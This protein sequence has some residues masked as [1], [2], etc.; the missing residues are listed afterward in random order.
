MHQCSSEREMRVRGRDVRRVAVLDCEGEGVTR[1]PLRRRDITGVELDERQVRQS[2]RGRGETTGTGERACFCKR[3]SR[4]LVATQEEERLPQR[5]ES[6]V[7][8]GASV[9]FLLEHEA[10]CTFGFG[11][12]PSQEY[13][14]DHRDRGAKRRDSVRKRARVRSGGG[15]LKPVLDLVAS[16]PA[17]PC[18][19]RARD[20]ELRSASAAGHESASSQ[21]V[22]VPPR[23]MDSRETDARVT[24]VLARSTFLL[25]IACV[26]ACS[27]SPVLLMPV[28][29]SCVEPGNGGGVSRF[30]LSPQH[31]REELVV[32][33]LGA[34]LVEPG[35]EEVQP[36]DL[37]ERRCGP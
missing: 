2:H 37:L 10:G 24:S 8:P 5:H 18:G 36:G 27:M 30:E 19:E 4:L 20:P 17:H 25:S 31:G 6:R 26:T 11:D 13:R 35:E 34:G 3:H 15:D 21:R 29:C 32:A 28:R 7:S 16:P 22:T 1:E 9:W 12:P 33:V 14:S 23:P